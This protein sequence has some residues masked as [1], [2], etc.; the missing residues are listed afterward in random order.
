M[1]LTFI[2][3]V[4]LLMVLPGLVFVK[5]SRLAWLNLAGFLVLVALGVELLD[6]VLAGHGAPVAE[7]NEF[8]RADALSAWMVLLI[9]IVSLAT[10]LYAVYYFRRELANATVTERR[11][12]EFYVLT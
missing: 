10:S 11:F 5:R 6:K 2:L 4:P 9:S 12:R 7:W 3:G 1:L 8:L